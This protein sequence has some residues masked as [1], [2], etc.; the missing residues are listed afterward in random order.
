MLFLHIAVALLSLIIVTFGYIKPSRSK[1]L[2]AY[3]LV[4]FTLGSGIYLVATA[5]TH[6]LEIC[7][8]GLLYI[9]F[10]VLGIIAMQAKLHKKALLDQGLL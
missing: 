3:S 2:S 4:G 7:S 10:A 1:L 8:V 9:A 5:H 6:M